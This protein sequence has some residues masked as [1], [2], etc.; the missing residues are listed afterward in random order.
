MAPIPVRPTRLTLIEN[1]RAAL[2]YY[3]GLKI[4]YQEFRAFVQGEQ[5]RSVLERG[6]QLVRE[7]GARKWLSDN[8]HFN[9]IPEE[10]GNWGVN[11]WSPQMIEAGWK[12]WAVVMP[13][14]AAG[15]MNLRRRIKVYGERGVTVQIFAD[16]DHAMEW[17]V[18]QGSTSVRPEGRP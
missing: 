2:W 3:P 1:E 15:R 11:E 5:F 9:P 7:H 8:R 17:L 12:Y 6:L 10:D 16:P 18:S 14:T 13:E 4:I